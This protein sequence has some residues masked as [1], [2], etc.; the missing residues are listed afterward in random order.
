VFAALIGAVAFLCLYPANFK[1]KGDG[2]LKPTVR[3]TLWAEVDGYV[4]NIS[5]KVVLGEPVTK[6]EVLVEQQSLDLEK[7]IASLIGELE[8]SIEDKGSTDQELFD[9]DELTEIERSQKVSHIAQLNK[10]IASLEKQLAWMNLKKEKLK[11]RS[12]M[13]GQVITWNVEQRLKNRPLNRGEEL[14]EVADFSSPWELEVLMPESRMGHIAKAKAE[15]DKAG[16]K[17]PVEFI[18]ALNPGETL[19]GVVEEVGWSAEVRGETGNTV[20]VLVSFDQGR[21]REVVTDPKIDNTATAKIHCGTRAIGYV[22]L[23]DLIDFVRA[24][25][26]FRIF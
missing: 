7:D 15:A 12:P 1:L 25:I 10:V 2:Q 19:Q 16:T 11:V 14:L 24:K 21:L 9:N 23:H 13:N 20:R 8:K 4:E 22:W 5:E 3:Q 26:L 17:L 6:G 18:L